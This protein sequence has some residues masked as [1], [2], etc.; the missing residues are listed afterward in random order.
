MTLAPCR[1]CGKENS[2]EI[3]IAQG[4]FKCEGCGCI[5]RSEN[6]NYSFYSNVGY[7]YKGNEVLKLYQKSIFVWFEDYI[8]PG[9]SVEFGAADGD[10]ISIVRDRIDAAYSVDYNELVDMLRPEYRSKDIG[11]VVCPLEEFPENKSYKNVFMINVLE[12]LNNPLVSLEKIYRMLEDGGRLFIA[13]D[14]GDAL[15]AHDEI[16]YYREHTCIFGRTGIEYVCS[17]IKFKL[18]AY[19]SSPF[20]YVF[21][22]LERQ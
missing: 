16:L 10:F 5:Y 11:V 12:H 13:T 14:D 17:K 19:F 8:L 7:W 2:N 6:M 18:V 9:K 15:N 20:G 21:T 1:L 4:I 22:V 3:V